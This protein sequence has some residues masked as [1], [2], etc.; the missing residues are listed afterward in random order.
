MASRSLLALCSPCPRARVTAPKRTSSAPPTATANTR[1]SANQPAS[2][3]WWGATLTPS[4]GARSSS[5]IEERANGTALAPSPSARYCPKMLMGRRKRIAGAPGHEFPD[6][7]GAEA[8]ESTEGRG[9][10]CIGEDGIQ[11]HPAH[12]P[13]TGEDRAPH[14]EQHEHRGESEQIVQQRQRIIAQVPRGAHGRRFPIFAQWS[15]GHDEWSPK[16]QKH[17]RICGLP[18]SGEIGDGQ[19]PQGLE[20]HAPAERM[21]LSTASRSQCSRAAPPCQVAAG[22]FGIGCSVGSLPAIILSFWVEGGRR[23]MAINGQLSNST[24][25]EGLGLLCSA[26]RGP[27]IKDGRRPLGESPS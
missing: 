22:K 21:V 10:H 20:W 13:P 12:A 18:R 3:A 26:P 23:L 19:V 6:Q 9:D 24:R 4:S 8:E 15:Y 17:P 27:G 5:G 16:K 25:T 2:A 11:R 1:L 14:T 7:R